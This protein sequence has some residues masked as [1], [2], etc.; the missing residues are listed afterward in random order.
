M[1]AFGELDV[2][3]DV[4]CAR[5][6]SKFRATRSGGPCRRCS[7]EDAE[8]ERREEVKH[9]LERSARSLPRWP[10][11]RFGDRLFSERTKLA[12]AM[13]IAAKAWTV[14][15][16]NLLFSGPTGIGKTSIAVA[17]LH[18]LHD[19]A[20]ERDASDA[21]QRL[22]SGA[23]FI[24]GHELV[25]AK[26]AHPLGRGLAPIVAEAV[27]ATVLLLDELGFE[28]QDEA[29]FFVVDERYRKGRPT[30][31]TTGLDLAGLCAKYGDAWV[32]RI[33]DLGELFE[34]KGAT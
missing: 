17:M 7:D 18:R 15:V 21:E 31:V 28:P 12:P 4:V 13:V 29:T 9:S 26:R 16:G 34:E 27:D 2:E 23:R 8:Q 11:A 19:R 22:A 10:W 33:L 14:R 24:T 25:A 5:C 20:V 1:R 32:R 30:I 3:R 6:G